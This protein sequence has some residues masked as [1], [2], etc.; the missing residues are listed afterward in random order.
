MT[1]FAKGLTRTGLLLLVPT[2]LAAAGR[3]DAT[4][5]QPP[6]GRRA[7]FLERSFF[8]VWHPERSVLAAPPYYTE[9]DRKRDDDQIMFE[10]LPAPHL[11]LQNRLA[12][13]D[14]KCGTRGD[15]SCPTKPATLPK[16]LGGR[17]LPK[18]LGDRSVIS[19]TFMS[20]LR[21]LGGFSSPLRNPSFMPRFS[22]Q[23]LSVTN[24]GN[25]DFDSKKAIKVFGPQLVLWG[26]HSNGGAGCLFVEDD[27]PDCTDA[28]PPERRT[29]NTRNGSFS[30]NYVKLAYFFQKGWPDRDADKWMRKSWTL[31]AWVELNPGGWGP[32]ALGP[33]Q[34][35]I[36]GPRRYGASLELQHQ[37]GKSRAP[38]NVSLNPTYEYIQFDDKPAA[39]SSP[40]RW[41]VDLTAV[42][43]DGAFKG[44]GLAVRFYQGQDFYNL[45]FVRDV[46]RL[47][48]GLVVDQNSRLLKA[49]E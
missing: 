14:L 17:T 25:G 23:R 22:F 8:F 38:W 12:F 26:H 35:A 18:F 32:G 40:H 21:Q 37:V 15:S 3:G 10:A 41:I 39:A 45:L 4:P 30:T 1:P 9:E 36:Y 31:G 33:G 16:F 7:F 13:D 20:R 5:G 29:V 43:E 49:G 44:W 6:Q 11:F 46:R 24:A 34:R 48:V 47:Q 42:K 2:A 28:L 27:E 19:F